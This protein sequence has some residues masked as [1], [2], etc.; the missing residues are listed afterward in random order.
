MSIVL[1]TWKC[2]FLKAHLESQTPL[3]AVYQNYNPLKSKIDNSGEI[4]DDSSISDYEFLSSSDEIEVATP[5]EPLSKSQ[6]AIQETIDRL[7]RLA[8]II[9]RSGKKHRQLRIERYLDKEK[10]REVYDRIKMLVFE[11]VDFSFPKASLAL[12]ERM[13]ESVAKR[14]SRFSYIEKHQQKIAAPNHPLLAPQPPVVYK[15]ASTLPQFV[16]QGIKQP[17]G[18]ASTILS[19]TEDTKLDQKQL[20]AVKEDHPESVASA[21]I[22]QSGFPDPPKLRSIDTTFHCPYCC[23]ECPIKEAHGE[24]WK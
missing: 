6:V 18:G 22:S 19:A 14:R 16:D 9:R 17:P 24:F 1:Y 2:S 20:R 3:N 7:H 13:A 8:T 10:N 4:N 5:N 11:K 23:L 12:K 21:Y 15:E